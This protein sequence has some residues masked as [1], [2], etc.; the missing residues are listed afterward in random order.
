MKLI[1]VVFDKRHYKVRDKISNSPLLKTTQVLFE[2]VH[3]SNKKTLIVFDQMESSL[4][5]E[6]GSHRKMLSILQ[7]NDGM[8]RIFVDEYSN[9]TDIEFQQSKNDNF[10]QLA[11]ICSYT[12]RRQFM[13]H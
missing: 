11:D 3:Y 10:L 1:A 12:I 13:E 9:I 5:K 4:R 7:S 8:E 2:R 6:K